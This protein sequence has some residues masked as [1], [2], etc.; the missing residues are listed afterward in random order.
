MPRKRKIKK[1]ANGEG[2][3]IKL[4]GTRRKP[5]CVRVT[6][7][8]DEDGRPIRKNLE[9]FETN[10]QAEDFLQL[11]NLMK[12]KNNRITIT[13]EQAKQI[14]SDLFDIVKEAVDNQK[15]MLTFAEIF[16]ILLEERY[17]QEKSYKSKISWFN[18]FK[19]LHDKNINTISLFDLQHVIDELKSSGRKEGTLSHMKCIAMDIFEY[20]V[21]HEYIKRDQDFTSYIDVSSNVEGSVSKTKIFTMDEIKTLL[22]DNSLEAKIVLIYL[23]TGCRPIDLFEIDTKNIYLNVDC[24][25]DG[26]HKIISYMIVSSKTEAGHRIVPIHKQIQPYIEELLAIHPDY[27]LFKGNEAK[28][29][30]HHY[31]KIIFDKLMKRLNMHHIPYDTRHTF[32]SLAK[33]FKVD[34]FARKR[35]VGH[36]SKDITDDVYTHIYINNLYDEIHKIKI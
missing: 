17:K 7:G 1:R 30:G 23:F 10:E 32:V 34:E 19:K 31:R 33:L 15:N 28:N 35:I 18:N 16:Q 20:G 3:I 12:K 27:L 5:Y 21:I 6:L 36:K 26:T 9:Y 22:N 14:D 13:D 2:A 29:I 25:D 8:R 11:Y 4:K 24:E